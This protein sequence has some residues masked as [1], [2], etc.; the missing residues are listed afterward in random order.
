MVIPIFLNDIFS[1]N[2]YCVT[3]SNKTNINLY[4]VNKLA[5]LL[6]KFAVALHPRLGTMPRH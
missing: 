6:T 5:L 4:D 2:E 3:L 1:T